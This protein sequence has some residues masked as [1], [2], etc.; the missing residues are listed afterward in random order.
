MEDFRL[1]IDLHKNGYRQG[2]GG[3]SETELAIRLSGL[4]TAGSLNILDV[5]CGTGAS[6]MVLASCLDCQITAIDIFDEF[7]AEVVHRSKEKGLQS[8]IRTRNCSMEDLPFAK[9]EFDVIW[10]EGS[11]YNM[12]FGNSIMAT[13][14]MV[15]KDC[16]HAPQPL[17]SGV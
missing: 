6:T 2:P 10:G 12:G 16:L 17:I 15:N 9:E 11:I 14:I 7:L 4:A 13:V 1:L 5:G 3:D 8:R